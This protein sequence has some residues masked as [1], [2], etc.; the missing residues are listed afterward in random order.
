MKKSAALLRS[1]FAGCCAVAIVILAQSPVL[2]IENGGIGGKPA[3]PN[4]D[5]PRSSSIFVYELEPGGVVADAVQVVNNTSSQKTLLVYPVDS[6]IASGGTFTCAQKIDQPISV[7]SWVKMDKTEVVLAPNS[8]QNVGFTINV[9]KTASAGES[10]GCIVIQDSDRQTSAQNSGISLSFRTAIRVAITV[11]G[12]IT[13][14]L[15]FTTVTA[16]TTDKHVINL[17]AGL[18]NNGNVSLDTELSVAVRTVFGTTARKAGGTFPVLARSEAAFN[19]ETPEPFWGGWYKVGATATYN[20][21]PNKSIGESGQT[22]TINGPTATIFVAPQPRALLIEA[23]G[24]I[25]VF[26][27]AGWFLWRRLHLYKLRSKSK[28]F[29][30]KEGVTLQKI[31]DAYG[32]SWK[33][34]AKINGLKPPYHLEPGSRIKIPKE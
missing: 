27:A 24:A 8:S 33:K 10:D 25:V 31:A 21:D 13:K 32:I 16:K 14:D 34:I 11:P 2:A 1:A 7:G 19:F 29:I 5:N 4:K 9:P 20:A 23:V 30:V 17:S 26:G 15:S 28:T 22:K 18:K 12:K 6:Q 3:N